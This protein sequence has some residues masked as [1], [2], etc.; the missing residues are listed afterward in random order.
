MLIRFCMPTV[1]NGVYALCSCVS[2]KSVF[3]YRHTKTYILQTFP[4]TLP[5]TLASSSKIKCKLIQL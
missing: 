1:C 3:I 5:R 2:L 4:E